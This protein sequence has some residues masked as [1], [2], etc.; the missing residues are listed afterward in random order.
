MFLLRNVETV[1]QEIYELFDQEIKRRF[2]PF[3]VCAL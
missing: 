1:D 2:V 3:A